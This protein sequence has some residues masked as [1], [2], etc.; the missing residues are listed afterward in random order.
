VKKVELIH[1]KKCGNCCIIVPKSV[2]EFKRSACDVCVEAMEGR[3]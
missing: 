3:G 2:N 1:I